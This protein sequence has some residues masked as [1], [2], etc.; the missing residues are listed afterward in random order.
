[1]IHSGL[2]LGGGLENLEGEWFVFWFIE[3]ILK[4]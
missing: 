2:E 1:M 4:N 3:L